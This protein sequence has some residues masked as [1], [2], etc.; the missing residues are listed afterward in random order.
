MQGNDPPSTFQV[1]GGAELNESWVAAGKMEPLNESAYLHVLGDALGSVG[2][3]IAGAVIYFF[4]WNIVD[5]IISVV[6]ALLILKGA[7][8]VFKDSIHILME[9]TPI[10]IDQQEEKKLTVSSMSRSSYLDHYFRIRLIKLSSIN[11]G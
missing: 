8:G 3:I 6:V 1:H 10:T 9:G 5:P 7:W 2:A 11:F 4:N